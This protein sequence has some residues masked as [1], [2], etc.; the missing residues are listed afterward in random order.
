MLNDPAADVVLGQRVL[1]EHVA[2]VY[3]TYSASTLTHL[4]FVAVFGAILY[5]QLHD[6][7][8]LFWMAGM[9]LA[10]VYVFF[11]PRWYPARPAVESPYWARKISRLVTLVSMVTAV[12]P[13]LVV[14]AGNLPMTSLLMAVIVGSCARASQ[15]LWPLKPALFGYTLPMSLGMIT[16]LAWQ[17]DGLHLF[18]AA[19][20]AAYLMLTLHAGIRQHRLLTDSLMLRF[21]NEALAARLGEQIAATERASLEK[22]RFLGTASHDLRQPLHAI[23]LFGAA[24]E[25]ELRHR[26]EGRNAER[27]MRAVNALGASLDTMLDVSRLDAGVVVPEVQAVQLD[28]LFLPLNHT[29]SARAEQKSLQLR[30]RA[31]GLWVRSDPQLLHRMLSNL[32]DNALKYTASGGV[33]VI[34]RDRG[35]TVWIEVRDTGIGIAPEQSGRIFEEFY[36]VDNPGRDRSHGLGIGLSIVQRLSRLLGH[37]VQMHS[38]LGRGTH[39]RLVVQAANAQASALAG[40]FPPQAAATDAEE[41]RHRGAARLPA[42]VLLLDDEQEIREAMTGLLRSHAVEAQAVD[43]EAAAARALAQAH[44]EGRPFEL[45]LCDYRLADGADGLDVGLRLSRAGGVPRRCC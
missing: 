2:S 44:G 6:P 8:L 27:L 9:V 26:P 38:R 11:T 19:A 29:F 45:L 40:P 10:D 3:D 32:M 20:G 15:S 33:T 42:R 1:R 34:A 7:R 39:F 37:P 13:W 28:A 23:A 43:D 16:A 5:A 14:P 21:E 25:N 4:C 18:L 31:S 35:E 41:Q 24:L 17:G 22:T 36:Q 12:V 30:V